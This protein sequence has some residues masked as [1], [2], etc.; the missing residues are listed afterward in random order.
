V[1]PGDYIAK[2]R[3]TQITN[4]GIYMESDTMLYFYD[5]R[6]NKVVKKK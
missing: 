6:G 3:I 4:D 5:I 1:D 2:R